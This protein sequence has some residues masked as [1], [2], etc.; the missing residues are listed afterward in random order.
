M[1]QSTQLTEWG[2][3]AEQPDEGP[4]CRIYK[5]LEKLGTKKIK[6]PI[7]KRANEL[8]RQFSKKKK[9]YKRLITIFSPVSPL[10]REMGIKNYVEIIISPRSEW[11]TPANLTTSLERMQRE[12]T[13]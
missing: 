9:K 8:N 4:T 2:G 12:R 6:R 7:N 3:G 13:H 1:Q 10:P 11:L 5:E